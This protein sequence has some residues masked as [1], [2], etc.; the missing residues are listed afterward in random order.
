MNVTADCLTLA[1]IFTLLHS[2]NVPSLAFTITVQH[3]LGPLSIV[4]KFSAITLPIC[5]LQ[6]ANITQRNKGS[7]LEPGY[8]RH[9]QLATQL[10]GQGEIQNHSGHCGLPAVN[11]TLIAANGCFAT[12]KMLLQAK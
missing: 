5:T 11:V 2:A 6:A 12:G 8:R 3:T 1:D 10:R 9:T 7:V 4:R